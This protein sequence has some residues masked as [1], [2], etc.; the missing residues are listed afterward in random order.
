MIHISEVHRIVER[1]EFSLR[2][3]ATTGEVI[4]AK[5]CICSSFHSDGR[6]MN[7]KFCDSGQI[8]KVRRCTI[9]SINQQ[10]VAL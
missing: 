4:E 5:R 7:I 2:F 9:I 8:R 3:V 10:E 6:T 1:G